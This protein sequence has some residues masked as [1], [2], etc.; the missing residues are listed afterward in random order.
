MIAFKK[1]DVFVLRNKKK[2]NL[3]KKI[4]DKILKIWSS[5]SSP[6][7]FS[8]DEKRPVNLI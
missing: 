6:Y 8:L 2:H 7:S 3:S 4:Y 5:Q 1:G